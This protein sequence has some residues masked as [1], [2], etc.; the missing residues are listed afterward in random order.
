M[1]NSQMEMKYM[2]DMLGNMKEKLGGGTT[3]KLLI[4]LG[5]ALAASEFDYLQ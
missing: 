1:T 4:N 5:K 3:R 2:I